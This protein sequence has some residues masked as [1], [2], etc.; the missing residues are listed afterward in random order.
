MVDLW[1]RIVAQIEA[2]LKQQADSA[3]RHP[4][5]TSP[6]GYGNACGMQA[7]LLRAL[8]I[9]QSALSEETDEDEHGSIRRVGSGFD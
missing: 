3:L 7:G 5:D 6:F 8:A 1:S 4:S 2:E 9:V